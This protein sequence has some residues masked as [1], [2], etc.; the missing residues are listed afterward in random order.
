MHCIFVQCLRWTGHQQ[1]AVCQTQSFL[2]LPSRMFFRLEQHGLWWSRPMCW[3]WSQ[4][5]NASRSLD[6]VLLE[7]STELFHLSVC[8]KVIV[9]PSNWIVCDCLFVQNLTSWHQSLAVT[10]LPCGG[11]TLPPVVIPYPQQWQPTPRE[12]H[13][14]S[15]SDNLPPAVTPHPR[16]WLIFCSTHT[17]PCQTFH[18][19]FD[20]RDFRSTLLDD[21]WRHLFGNWSA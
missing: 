15:S 16:Q 14:T 11:N 13:P 2:A 8:C 9:N 6:A 17:H 7:S 19:G 18:P 12:W 4:R 5:G 1:P 20:G 10:S 21:L 3:L